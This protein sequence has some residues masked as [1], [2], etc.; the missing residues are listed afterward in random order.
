MN[1]KIQEKSK[2]KLVGIKIKRAGEQEWKDLPIVWKIRQ[3]FRELGIQFLNL[4]RTE[5]GYADVL[6][7]AGEEW[8]VDVLDGVI[9]FPQTQ[10]IGWGTGTGTHSKTSTALFTESTEARVAATR[11]QPAADKIRYIGT[12]TADSAKTITNAGVLSASTGGTLI[13]ASDFTGISLAAGDSIQFTW[14][15]EIT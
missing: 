1:T 11:S 14:D 9:V 7:Q 4:F 13:L 5:K 15:R 2:A 8:T 3:F 6:T 10:Y 12:L